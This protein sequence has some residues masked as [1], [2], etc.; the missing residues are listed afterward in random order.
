MSTLPPQLISTKEITSPSANNSF[1]SN[2]ASYEETGLRMYEMYSCWNRD[3]SIN[4]AQIESQSVDTRINTLECLFKASFLISLNTASN[5]S[6]GMN[7]LGD[8]AYE[9]YR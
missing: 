1:V 5:L 2:K 8:Y 4:P 6:L 9:Y 3:T 7:I